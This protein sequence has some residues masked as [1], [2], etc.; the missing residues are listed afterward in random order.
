MSGI[1]TI[2]TTGISVPDH[3]VRFNH[4]VI[5]TASMTLDTASPQLGVGFWEYTEAEESIAARLVKINIDNIA[6]GNTRDRVIIFSARVA[7][8]EIVGS[9]T[10]IILPDGS[11]EPESTASITILGQR[12]MLAE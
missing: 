2:T 3:Y 5:L 10:A 4:G 6:G 11:N 12:V 8:D 1:W 9:G 7:M